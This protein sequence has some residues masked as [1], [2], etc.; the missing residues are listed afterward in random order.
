[1]TSMEEK[2]LEMLTDTISKLA[3]QFM[4]KERLACTEWLIECESDGL[5]ETKDHQE[6]KNEIIY[7]LLFDPEY[8]CYV[9]KLLIKTNRLNDIEY[10]ERK[11]REAVEER[12][13]ALSNEE[14]A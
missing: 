12:I 13:L 2:I 9:R 10:H 14:E 3:E 11:A 4:V 5:Y 8:D 7:K 1:M 6:V